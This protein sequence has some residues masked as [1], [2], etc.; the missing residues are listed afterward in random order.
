M[1]IFRQELYRSGHNGGSTLAVAYQPPPGR[2]ERS[3][4]AVPW[5]SP[6]SPVT[7]LG[8]LAL[9]AAL[10]H[11]LLFE[12]NPLRSLCPRLPLLLG[13]AVCDACGALSEGDAS[14]GFGDEYLKRPCLRCRLPL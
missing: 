13:P 6:Y 8:F 1:P 3:Q 2:P 12:G 10:D 7:G 5:G 11:L 14:W 4:L 9:S